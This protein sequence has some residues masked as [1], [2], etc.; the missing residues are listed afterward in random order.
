MTEKGAKKLG[1]VLAFSQ[2]MIQLLDKA[3]VAAETIWTEKGTSSLREEH[4]LLEKTVVQLA[5]SFGTTATVIAKSEKTLEKLNTMRDMYIKDEWDNPTEIM[6]W[7]GFFAGA[8]IVHWSLIGGIGDAEKNNELLSLT[9][10]A[11]R[12][13]QETFVQVKEYLYEKGK[14]I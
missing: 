7:L 13:W 6:E 1:E 3:K 10:K 5:D 2:G 8:A 14:R 9:E 4:F 11:L 12:K